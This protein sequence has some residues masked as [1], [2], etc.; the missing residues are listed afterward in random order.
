MQRDFRTLVH[1]GTFHTEAVILLADMESVCEV[2]HRLR[3]R[4]R[5]LTPDLV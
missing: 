3:G 1:L 2:G 4:F 5:L